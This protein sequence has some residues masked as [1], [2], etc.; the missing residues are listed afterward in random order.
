M[1]LDFEAAPSPLSLPSGHGTSAE[2]NKRCRVEFKR[3]PML[4]LTQRKSYDQPSLGPRHWRSI[5]HKFDD[6]QATD[7]ALTAIATSVVN[8]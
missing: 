5:R 4:L 7:L 1:S 3:L 8:Q 2:R 6:E